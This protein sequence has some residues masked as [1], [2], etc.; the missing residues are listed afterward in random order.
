MVLTLKEGH[1]RIHVARAGAHRF[2]GPGAIARCAHHQGHAEVCE[3]RPVLRDRIINLRRRGAIEVNL[4]DVPDDPDDAPRFISRPTGFAVPTY[5][6]ASA[7]LM[8]M[9]GRDFAVSVVMPRPA[10]I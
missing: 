7:S 2:D 8:R 9:T 5:A 1:T 3:L 6:R 10:R 4:P